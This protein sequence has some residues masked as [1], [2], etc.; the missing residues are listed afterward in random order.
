MSDARESH[1]NAVLVAGR[2]ALG[3]LDAPT[4]L[5]DRADPGGV[6]RIDRVPKREKR[7]ADHDAIL[8]YAIT[9]AKHALRARQRQRLESLD[10]I[11]LPLAR[12]DE[13]KGARK[14]RQLAHDRD[15]VGFE[16]SAYGHAKE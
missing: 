11:R 10:A 2:D 14:P 5:D 16:R 1:R 13:L 8:E 15:R 6:R 7:I 9:R 4:R 12:A 3:I